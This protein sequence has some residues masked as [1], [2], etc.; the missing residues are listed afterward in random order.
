MTKRVKT[1]FVRLDKK[2]HFFC[3]LFEN[4]LPI[5]IKVVNLQYQN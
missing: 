5:Q 2:S 1:C 4:V 3:F